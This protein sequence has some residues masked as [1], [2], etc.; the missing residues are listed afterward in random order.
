MHPVQHRCGLDRPRSLIEVVIAYFFRPLFSHD[1]NNTNWE[2]MASAQDVVILAIDAMENHRVSNQTESSFTAFDASSG[3]LAVPRDSPSNCG[4]SDI[5]SDQPLCAAA[6]VRRANKLCKC[7]YSDHPFFLTAYVC[8]LR[9][10]LYVSSLKSRF[11]SR[12][13]KQF[14]LGR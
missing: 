9:W 13:H 2:L 4:M 3:I 11:S 10:S 8:V 5:D 6:R 7:K 1:F 12:Q 14:N